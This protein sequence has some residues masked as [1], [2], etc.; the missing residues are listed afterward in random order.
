MRDAVIGETQAEGEGPKR[1]RGRRRIRDGLLEG[2]RRIQAVE[3]LELGGARTDETEAHRRISIINR[4]EVVVDTIAGDGRVID[5]LDQLIT[6]G[7]GAR[8][9]SRQDHLPTRA[10]AGDVARGKV[11]VSAGAQGDRDRAAL[12]H[13]EDA[14]LSWLQGDI[15]TAANLQ[16]DAARKIGPHMLGHAEAGAVTAV[17]VD[18]QGLPLAISTETGDRET[19]VKWIPERDDRLR[20]ESCTGTRGRRG[21]DILN[22]GNE[23]V[24]MDTLVIAIQASR[25]GH[26]LGLGREHRG[27]TRQLRIWVRDVFAI[28]QAEVGEVG[29]ATNRREGREGRVAPEVRTAVGRHA[30]RGTPE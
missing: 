30:R 24:T 18:R 26:H 6:E 23:G 8:R 5:V 4:V 9:G 17:D 25:V 7:P 12:V 21:E 2:I 16:A 10:A 14:R 29:P 22:T 20:N 11:V 15:R 3:L 27:D 13:R 19:D 28:V 1:A